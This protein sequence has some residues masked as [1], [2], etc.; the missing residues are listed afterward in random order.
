M[1]SQNHGTRFLVR[2]TAFFTAYSVHCHIACTDLSTVK[3][4]RAEPVTDEDKRIKQINTAPVTARSIQHVYAIRNKRSP[5]P[6]YGNTIEDDATAKRWRELKTA[7]ESTPTKDQLKEAMTL[8]GLGPEEIGELFNCSD[9]YVSSTLNVLSEKEVA[10]LDMRYPRD[11]DDE[12]EEEDDDDDD[13]DKEAE[14]DVEDSDED[15]EEDE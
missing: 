10:A 3:M 7:A 15:E 14:D 2:S 12:E 11:E 1:Q 6:D 4:R 13:F 8:L 5:S 9:E